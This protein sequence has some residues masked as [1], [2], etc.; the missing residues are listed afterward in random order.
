MTSL[1][2]KVKVGCLDWKTSGVKE[3]AG[4][5]NVRKFNLPQVRIFVSR[6]RSPSKAGMKG[7]EGELL[8]A[9]D[10]RL[11]PKPLPPCQPAQDGS[12]LSRLRTVHNLLPAAAPPPLVDLLLR[13]RQVAAA[14]LKELEENDAAEDGQLQKI[15]LALGGGGGDD[16]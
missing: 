2:G 6:A 5:F 16:L 13:L 9:A 15:T 12:V 3:L 7:D 1:Q 10:V 11:S 4:E 8:P 14:V